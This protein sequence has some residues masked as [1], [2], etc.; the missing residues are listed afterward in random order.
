M[1]VNNVLKNQDNAHYDM[2]VRNWETRRAEE[3][4][5]LQNVERWRQEVY[6][7]R[8]ENI[9]TLKTSKMLS[10]QLVADH[11]R[12][13][14]DED[15]VSTGS[16]FA[17]SSGLFWGPQDDNESARRFAVSTYSSSVVCIREICDSETQCLG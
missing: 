17:A 14:Q 8:I 5:S 13:S 2:L 4:Q 10:Q 6:N 15:S 9:R 12:R 7:M 16:S 11:K 3:E 1:A